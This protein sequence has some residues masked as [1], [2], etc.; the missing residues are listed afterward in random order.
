ML[1]GLYRMS[2][3]SLFVQALVDRLLRGTRKAAALPSVMNSRGS[4]DHLV[5]AG[6]QGRRKVDAERLRRLEID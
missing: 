1:L 3:P 5:G 2:A 6:E 4:F